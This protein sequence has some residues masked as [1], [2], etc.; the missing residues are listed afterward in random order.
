MKPESVKKPFRS[1][2]VVV[3]GDI[4]EITQNVGEKGAGDNSGAASLRRRKIRRV[5]Q[6]ELQL[7]GVWASFRVNLP[8]PG[9]A[10]SSSADGRAL[11]F[12]LAVF[13]LR[14]VIYAER[15][16]RVSRSPYC[17]EHGEASLVI[18]QSN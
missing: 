13:S 9:L 1:P 10:V 6:S 17:N 4:R 3:Y 11:T 15:H 16:T 8:L 7:F 18:W 14:L 12:R 2:N 5:A